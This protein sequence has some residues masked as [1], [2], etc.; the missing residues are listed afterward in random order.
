M[1]YYCPKSCNICGNQIGPSCNFL[2]DVCG[3]FGTCSSISYFNISTIQ[4]IC[5]NGYLGAACNMCNELNFCI[6]KV[7]K[8]VNLFIFFLKLIYAGSLQ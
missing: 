6:F 7:I 4:C 8:S 5:D 3:N 1:E 2:G